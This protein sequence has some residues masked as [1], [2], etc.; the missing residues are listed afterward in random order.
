MFKKVH[1]EYMWNVVPPDPLS[2]NPS[3]ELAVGGGG[4]DDPEAAYGDI[5]EE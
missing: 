5:E 1:Q 4:T 2:P 3:T